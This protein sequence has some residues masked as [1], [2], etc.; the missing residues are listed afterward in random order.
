[1]LTRRVLMPI[2]LIAVGT[3][4]IAGTTLLTLELQDWRA[5]ILLGAAGVVGSSLFWLW[6]RRGDEAP[7]ISAMR[8]RLAEKSSRLQEQAET[9]DLAKT[10]LL[11]E[12]NIRTQRLD[13]RERN[14]ASRLVR[15]HEFLEYPI[16]DI[17]AERESGQLQQLS[18]KDRRVRELLENEAE[19]VYEKIRRNGYTIEGRFDALAIRD[20]ALQL[21]Q[22]V[23]KIYKP[24]SVNPL[25]ETSFD[26]LARAASRVCLHAL[27]VLETLP[28]SVQHYSINTLYS[29][30]QRAVMGYGVYQ[31]A[32][33]WLSYL[34]R[35]LYAG[36]LVSA[37]N[38]AA[39]GAWWLATELGKKGAQKVLE[40][41]VDRQAVALL[42]QLVIVVGVEAAGLYGTGFRQRD[43]AW[44]L[45]TEL[46][47]L[48]H[49]F[50][51]SEASLKHGLRRITVL[52]LRSEYDRVYLYRCLANHRSAGLHL[53]D[54]G[55][56]SREERETMARQLEQFFTTYIHGAN[57]ANIKRWR[58]R[59]EH[60]FDL[61]LKLDSPQGTATT[62]RSQQIE[63]AARS[64]AGFLRRIVLLEGAPLEQAVR[65]LRTF[66]MLSESQKQSLIHELSVKSAESHFEPPELDPGSD[67]T[68]IFL[69]DLSTCCTVLEQPDDHLEQLVCE[70][71]RYFRRPATEARIAI[72]TAWRQ[73]LR[74]HCLDESLADE[75]PNGLARVFF[76]HRQPDEKLAFV[77]GGLSRRMGASLLPIHNGW[78]M[79]L[80]SS[81]NGQ[82]RA[83][84]V[85]MENSTAVI[86]N[87]KAPLQ[88][89]RVPGLMIDDALIKGG[90]WLDDRDSQPAT[91]DPPDLLVSGSLRGGRYKSYFRNLL[92]FGR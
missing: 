9:L 40:N 39:L 67:L 90:T 10:A 66:S 86:W 58:E 45:G 60:R 84:A 48:I 92:D 7:E 17:H 2:V 33:P 68:D 46:V 57:E 49:A 3:L 53:A 21:V 76:L 54:P 81:S 65:S 79:A 59:V 30:V 11:D 28:V 31:K 27:V 16:E 4:L 6:P 15:F 72:E 18:E 77:Y 64:E 50:P 47:E 71:C 78:L 41:V 62:S 80:V 12:L 56:L 61:K 29:Y 82:R 5:W 14:L 38:P 74:W 35:G 34:S 8:L 24:E 83:I 63:H 22:Q 44:I 55:M 1:M 20:E 52:P 85:A 43:P 23:A 13:E 88:V 75:L 70:T 51:P 69:K 89:D 42:H 73:R 19:R 91:G 26:Q 32:S 87:A 25:L 37:T 36:R